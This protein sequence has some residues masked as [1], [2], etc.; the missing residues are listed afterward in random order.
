M[1]TLP[2]GPPKVPLVLEFAG[3]TVQVKTLSG[4]VS[5]KMTQAD[6]TGFIIEV[7]PGNFQF[8]SY[9]ECTVSV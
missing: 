8:F 2:P 1:T 4:V 3:Q 6:A 9:G 7:A 5:G